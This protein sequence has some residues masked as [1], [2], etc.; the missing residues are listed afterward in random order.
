MSLSSENAIAIAIGLTNSPDKTS[1][2]LR[3]A[4]ELFDINNGN[5]GIF[6]V[7]PQDINFHE[8]LENL[9]LS[10][11]ERDILYLTQF[12]HEAYTSI[13]VTYYVMRDSISP[14]GLERIYNVHECMQRLNLDSNLLLCYDL[15]DQ[16]EQV[17]LAIK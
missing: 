6:S 17:L 1:K 2:I 10:Q 4:K 12:F 11:R 3:E 9:N 13:N 15:Q 5:D 14:V 7:L 16:I 8:I